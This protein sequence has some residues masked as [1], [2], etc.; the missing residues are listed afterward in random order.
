VR[1]EAILT[2]QIKEITIEKQHYY[3][4]RY[5]NV[6]ELKLQAE[7]KLIKAKKV[8]PLTKNVQ[9]DQFTVG[10]TVRV[11]GRWEGNQFYF[12]HFEVLNPVDAKR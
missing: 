1:Q 11:F 12:N 9:T 2:G 3:D 8:T 7:V 10:E 6:Q 4:N 5:I